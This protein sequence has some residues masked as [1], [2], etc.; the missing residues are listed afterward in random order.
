MQ[1]RQEDTHHAAQ[2]REERQ[3]LRAVLGKLV[4]DALGQPCDLLGT[5]VR[6]LWQDHYR[7]NVF[8]GED[9]ASAKI[10]HSYFLVVNSDGSVIQSI[11]KITRQY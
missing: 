11:P 9:A 5:Q 3:Q 8:V 6:P 4:L 7:V 2:K 1:T 10:A